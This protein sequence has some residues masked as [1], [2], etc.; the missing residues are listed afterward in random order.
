[1]KIDELKEL[2][3][4]WYGSDAIESTIVDWFLGNISLQ[5]SNLIVDNYIRDDT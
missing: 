5:L 2:V 4:D 1:M 3:N